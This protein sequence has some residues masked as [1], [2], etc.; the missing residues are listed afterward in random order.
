[1]DSVFSFEEAKEAFHYYATGSNFGKV[2]I[3][4]IE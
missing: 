1:M 4:G 2:V 3:R